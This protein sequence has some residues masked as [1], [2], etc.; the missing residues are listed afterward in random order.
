MRSPSAL[1]AAKDAGPSLTAAANAWGSWRPR[2]WLGT[3]E[4]ADVLL[5]AEKAKAKLKRAKVQIRSTAEGKRLRTLAEGAG[6]TEEDLC[7]LLDEMDAKT[8]AENAL[9][10]HDLEAVANE[11]LLRDCYNT[12]I[13]V[14]AVVAL[15]AGIDAWETDP[16]HNPTATGMLRRCT[17]KCNGEGD[18]GDGL[19]IA[20]WRGPVFANGPHSKPKPWLKLCD[21]HGQTNVTAAL[22][23]QNGSGT[24]Y[25]HAM[26]ADL[27]INLGR[28][29]YV[30]P[31]GLPP[32]QAPPLGS[33]VLLWVPAQRER[34]REEGYKIRAIDV[35][36]GGKKR[37]RV[38]V[39]AATAGLPLVPEDPEKLRLY[40]GKMDA[41]IAG[42]L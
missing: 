35:D 31:P 24:Y 5:A 38:I 28:L 13:W 11:K 34:I 4:V 25:E 9:T 15:I 30:A 39:R 20:N 23:Q 16:F 40:R 29:P 19:R 37:H 42:L 18:A 8:A 12:P 17:T 27:E 21:E 36:V 7:R 3:W 33:A 32:R 6:M 41:R 10:E 22:V 2:G 26:R 14:P 1:Q